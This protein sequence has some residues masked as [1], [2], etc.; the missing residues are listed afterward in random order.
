[1][2]KLSPVLLLILCLFCSS[3]IAQCRAAEIPAGEF[4]KRR[5]ALMGQVKKGMIILFADPD[6]P[7]ASRFRQDNDFYYFTGCDD[8]NAILV[9]I[10]RTGETALF[11]PRLKRREKRMYGDNL[12]G[13][14]GAGKKTGLTGI[15]PLDYFKKYVAGKGKKADRTFYVRLSP[16]DEVSYNRREAAMF[17]ERRARNPFNDQIP[18]DLYRVNKLKEQYPAFAV[19]DVVP[20]IDRMRLLKTPREIEILRLNGKIS[21]EAIKRAMLATRPGAYEYELEAA[22]MNVILKNGANGPA[23][24]PII[25]SGPNSCIFHYNKNN[26]QMEAGDVVLMDF[27]ADLAHLC[28]DITR[29]WP[30]SGTFTPE[31]REVYRAVL[32]VQKACIAAYRPGIT[33]KDVRRRVAKVLKEKGIDMKGLRGGMHHY[34]GLS[35]HDV[36]PK[37]IPFRE[38]MV[39]TIEPGLYY[40]EKNLGIRIEDTILI[41]K[42]GCEVLSKDVP[43]EIAEIEALLKGKKYIGVLH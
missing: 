15:Y 1:M 7:P 24:A 39:F 32:E 5:V 43:K 26:R 3:F 13:D 33:A 8:L 31:Q 16:K 41:T 40:P 35:V 29:T 14:P 4:V 17:R 6:H 38:G 9:M 23:Y 27:G 28:M 21:A 11:L 37:G 30:V 19:K 25:G 10:P 22:A 36:G 42:D 2:R 34:V 12:L 18:A 20:F